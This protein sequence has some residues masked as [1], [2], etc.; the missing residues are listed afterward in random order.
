M[1]MATQNEGTLRIFL[2]HKAIDLPTAQQIATAFKTKG[3]GQVD[4][5]YSGE[6]SQFG[7]DYRQW[8]EDKLEAAEWYILA[9]TEP[10]NNWDWCLYEAGY[11]EACQ[12]SRN[13]QNYRI[14]CLHPDE[15]RPRP[16]ERFDS[17]SITAEE[18]LSRLGEEYINRVNPTLGADEIAQE[19][20]DFVQRICEAF[21]NRIKTRYN[22][23]H[24]MLTVPEPAELPAE[25]LP[26]TA[27]IESDKA[28]MSRLFRFNGDRAEWSRLRDSPATKDMRWVTQLVHAL[29]DVHDD[30]VPQPITGNIEIHSEQLNL[31]P[32]L[33][34]VDEL[35]NGSYQCEI[36]LANGITSRW[37]ALR[38]P[39][40][41]A[42]LTS[43]RM[44][45]RFRYDVLD[46]YMGKVR[47]V[48]NEQGPES[49]RNEI[50]N[51]MFD[52]ITEAAAHGLSDEQ[53]MV[54]C[55]EHEQERERINQ[56]FGEWNDEIHPRLFGAIGMSPDPSKWSQLDDRQFEDG[57]IQ[58]IE[59]CFARLRE[60]NT[61]FLV[62]ALGRLQSYIES[63]RA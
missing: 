29:K 22:G 50:R 13:D 59:D 46:Q 36:L 52:I 26:D 45:I 21:Q 32:V 34:R 41:R 17:I 23:R 54:Q 6:K 11:F 9:Y 3:A 58:D 15:D 4:I 47:F 49:F 37:T 62:M 30:H 55:F 48:I 1:N 44:T 18:S 14:I 19:R 39:S 7:K 33:A 40:V 25:N 35:A 12:K 43:I 5:S 63:G 51:L 10:L 20:S 42:L 57:E 38:E 27:I 60:I 61:E 53:L 56:F 28:I 16:L 31:L 8:I 24:L 2:S